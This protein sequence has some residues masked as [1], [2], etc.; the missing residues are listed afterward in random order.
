MNKEFDIL[1]NHIYKLSQQRGYRELVPLLD[2]AAERALFPE[3]W[4]ASKS[5]Q[6]STQL[7]KQVSFPNPAIAA[8]MHSK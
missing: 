6:R 2:K 4:L 1:R 5:C 8:I 7:P 3:P